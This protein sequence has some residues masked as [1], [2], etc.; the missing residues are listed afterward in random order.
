[1]VYRTPDN[2]PSCVKCSLSTGKSIHSTSKV[3]FK[4]VLLCI[5]SDYPSIIEERTNI[6]L[7]PDESKRNA[8]WFLTKIIENIFDKDPE[9]EDKY[10]PFY[11]Y[12]LFGN[13]IRCNPMG[14]RGDKANIKQ[15]DRNICSDW[16]K[17][18]L[19]SININTP[20]LVAGSE[21]FKVFLPDK[22]GGIKENRNKVH[23]S[24]FSGKHPIIVSYNPIIGSNCIKGN[25]KSYTIK[26]DG[27][28]VPKEVIYPFEYE[29][30]DP[31][32]FLVKDYELAKRKVLE[33]IS[34]RK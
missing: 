26:K 15:S 33:S 31:I 1:M 25:I 20:I 30:L 2:D 10:K 24:R 32:Y 19:S 17:L 4:D 6:S 29:P 28:R 27:S 12:I 13:V 11:N 34:L 22:K 5:Y 14:E 9:L 23:Y 18:D 16:T 7:S 8:G 21:A 3:P